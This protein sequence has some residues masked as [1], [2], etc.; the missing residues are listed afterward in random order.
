[1]ERKAAKRV[2]SMKRIV[3]LALCCFLT[4]PAFADL[5]GIVNQTGATL[6]P[7]AAATPGTVGS[8]LATD[9]AG[10]QLSPVDPSS[11]GGQSFVPASNNLLFNGS[12]SI[13][14][15]YQVVTLDAVEAASTATVLNLTAHVAAAGDII[16]FPALSQSA[17]LFRTWGVVCSV[18]TNTVTLCNAL[19]FTPSAAQDVAIMRSTPLGAIGSSSTGIT[20]LN[21]YLEPGLNTGTTLLLHLEDVAMPDGVAGVAPLYTV[22]S[23]I[24]QA[25]GATGR[26]GSP[27]TDLGGRT[28]TTPAPSGS[29][30]RGCNAAV[31][32]AT[33][34]TILAAVASNYTFLTTV[35]CT[36]SGAAASFITIEDS[37]G[38]DMAVGYLP[39][40]TGTWSVSFNIVPSRTSSVN[41]GIQVN[42]ATTNTSTVCC[43]NSYTGVI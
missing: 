24:T 35:T 6:Y 3:A 1:V 40:T 42:V 30:Y 28:I 26:A 9:R 2:V 7:S 31:T 5:P 8:Q 22:E 41:Q 43:A 19:P 4:V 38:S 17:T 14:A 23:A 39:A 20:G 13:P 11:G 27:K 33:T 25:V 37:G 18:T 16:R 12:P 29:L 15:G 21:T 32:T 36:N 10:R 34:G